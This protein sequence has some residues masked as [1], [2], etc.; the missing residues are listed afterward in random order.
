MILFYTNYMWDNQ[1]DELSNKLATRKKLN[2]LTMIYIK[3]NLVRFIFLGTKFFIF[4]ILN[5]KLDFSKFLRTK[6]SI[7]SLYNK[8]FYCN[9]IFIEMNVFIDIFSLIIFCM[10]HTINYVKILSL[11]F[12]INI[13]YFFHFY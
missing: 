7:Y 13:Y 4:F 1:I 10:S 5:T 11:S 8:H 9:I 6:M 2:F 12:I 3:T